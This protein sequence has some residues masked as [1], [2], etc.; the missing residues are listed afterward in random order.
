MFKKRKKT[1]TEIEQQPI[2]SVV[3]VDVSIN[4]DLVSENSIRIDGAVNGKVSVK[5]GIIIGEKS[6]IEG[7]V[8]CEGMVVYGT[9]NGNIQAKSLYIKSTGKINGDISVELIEIEVGGVYNGKLNMKP[10]NM[11]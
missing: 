7:D 1:A 2:T 5:N 8:I 11:L 9:V 4:G 10:N 3:G 6:A